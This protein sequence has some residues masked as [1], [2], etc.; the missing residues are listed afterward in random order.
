[1]PA[2]AATLLAILLGVVMVG[3]LPAHVA[4]ADH[5]SMYVV[6][7]SPIPEGNSDHMR[8]RRSGY[9]ILSQTVFTYIG[10]H[11]ADSSDFVYY[12]GIPIFN[13]TD[14]RSLWVPVVTKEDSK[15][16]HDETFTIGFWDGGAWHG[17]V[18]TIEDDDAPEITEVAI[19]SI[20]VEG[21][22]YR[23][24]ES[25]DITVDLDREAEVEETALLSLYL[26]KGDDTTWRGAHYYHGSG[27]KHLTFR[28]QV[29]PTDRD[30]DGISV[31]AAHTN[32]DGTPAYGF[33]GRIF[34][35]GTDVPIDY[36]HPGIAAAP[37][38]RV[39]GRPYVENIEVT[40]SPPGDQGAYRAGQVIEIAVKFN[41]EVE[42]DGEPRQ[43][44]Y[45]GFN[46][47]NWAQSYRDAEYL[48]GSGA[49]TLVFGYTVRS[50][51]QDDRG[52]KI[53]F[54]NPDNGIP[55]SGAVRA[56]GTDVKMNPYYLGIGHQ[57]DHQVDA[58]APT[59]RSVGISSRPADGL[60][61][62]AGEFIEV[63]VAFSEGVIASGN[64]HLELDI[65]GTT[66]KADLVRETGGER[67]LADRMTFRYR[68]QAGDRDT[69]GVGIR[70]NSLQLN[71]GEIGDRAG[72]AAGLAHA[73]VAADPDQRVDASTGT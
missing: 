62:G 63:V 11:T 64:P 6:C 17:C 12:D 37:G 25:I 4:Y 18:I 43:G 26:G 55:R 5:N 56:K 53:G 28:Y 9:R 44:L 8:V 24:G 35:E 42:V 14:S 33:S 50:G 71:G 1:M 47:T 65:D 67:T 52:V 10:D 29:Q 19:T 41:I 51:D 45:V 23:T 49:D 54:G 13:E 68:V 2:W 59:I 57:E 34:A 27:S 36:T 60:A 39:D 69:D 32:D 48:R 58:V 66:G 21:D 46:R 73:A 38:H 16:E 72:N 3:P 7:P 15:A 22:T 70:S 40:S 30:T 31:S 20:P 61:Y